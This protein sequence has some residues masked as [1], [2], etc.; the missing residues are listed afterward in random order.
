MQITLTYNPYIQS[1]SLTHGGADA[2]TPR[3]RE[4]LRGDMTQWLHYSVSSY[5]CWLGLLPEL[6]QELNDDVLVIVFRGRPEDYQV[7]R[8]ALERQSDDLTALG[9]APD[10]WTL[11]WEDAFS[12]EEVLRNIQTV[13]EE[14]EPFASPDQAVAEARAQC[15]KAM[16]ACPKTVKAVEEMRRKWIDVLEQAYAADG[17]EKRK[18]IWAQAAESLEDVFRGTGDEQEELR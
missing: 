7:F 6:V 18:S 1:V 8:E 9:F 14:C 15:A 3:L 16:A 13:V 11:E 4:Y 2:S 17:S 5:R 12:P 10:Q